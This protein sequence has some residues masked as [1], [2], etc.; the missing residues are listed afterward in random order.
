LGTKQAYVCCVFEAIGSNAKG[1]NRVS[2]NAPVGTKDKADLFSTHTKKQDSRR[3]L[4]LSINEH[5]QI[6]C[7]IDG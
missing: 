7:R 2:L 1:L 6:I 5:N 4:V 3:K